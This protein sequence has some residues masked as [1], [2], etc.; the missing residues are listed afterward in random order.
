[1]AFEVLTFD[2]FKAKLIGAVYRIA[3]AHRPVLD[4]HIFVRRIVIFAVLTGERPLKTL[5][6]LV[7]HYIRTLNWLGAIKALNLSKLAAL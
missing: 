5:V 2:D 1:V 6:I 4:C 3:T 7:D